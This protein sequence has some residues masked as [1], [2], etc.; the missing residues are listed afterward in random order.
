MTKIQAGGFSLAVSGHCGYG[1]AGS[2][3]VCASVSALCYTLAYNLSLE[4]GKSVLKL[5]AALEPG[6]VKISCVPKKGK[7]REVRRIFSVVENGLRMIAENYPDH[8]SEA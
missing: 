7:E 3:I 4:E 5:D 6:K 2:D 8:V 1:P